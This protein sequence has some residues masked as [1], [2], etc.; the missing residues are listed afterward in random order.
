ME[1]EPKKD[2]KLAPVVRHTLQEV[3]KVSLD[4]EMEEQVFDLGIPRCD[5]QIY[6]SFFWPFWPFPVRTNGKLILLQSCKP[7]YVEQ[8]KSK[9]IKPRGSVETWPW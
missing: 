1:F 4:Q 9:Q 8:L 5:A 2:M 3:D 7:L 6:L